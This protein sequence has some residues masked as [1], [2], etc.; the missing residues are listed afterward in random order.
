VQIQYF[1]ADQNLVFVPALLALLAATVLICLPIVFAPALRRSKR[2]APLLA[3]VVVLAV[4]AL[5]GTVVL[6][7]PGFRT[8]GAERAA[9]RAGIERD[10]GL[11]VTDGEAN[12]LVNGGRPARKMPELAAQLGLEKPNDEHP[13]RLVPEKTGSDV[14]TLTFGGKPYPR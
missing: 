5:V 11:Q 3:L 9:V 10:Y 13:L 7:L 6:A 14:Y 1:A 12:E 4:V 2:R 8:L